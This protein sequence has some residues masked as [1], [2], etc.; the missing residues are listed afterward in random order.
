MDNPLFTLDNLV[1]SSHT[2]GMTYEG[3]KKVV[4]MSF[5]NIIDL[6]NGV[7]PKGLVNKQVMDHF[8]K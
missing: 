4:D 5:Q 8:S 3:R 6:S 7:Q 1:V 2:A